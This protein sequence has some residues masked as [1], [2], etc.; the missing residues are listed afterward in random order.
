MACVIGQVAETYRMTIT[1]MV[2]GASVI[3]ATNSVVRRRNRSRDLEFDPRDVFLVID[4]VWP[5]DLRRVRLT[6]AVFPA[7]V[8]T[9]YGEWEE[10]SSTNSLFSKAP[11]VRERKAEAAAK[12]KFAA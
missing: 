4:A 11:T 12:G 7:A 1:R 9:P 10:C 6:S 8:V 3:E 5:E 2:A